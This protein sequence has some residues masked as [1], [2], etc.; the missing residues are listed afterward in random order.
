VAK[1]NWY[2]QEINRDLCKAT[3]L[4]KG[5]RALS[6]QVW[7][8]LIL[9]A[10]FNFL[11]REFFIRHQCEMVNSP[12]QLTLYGVGHLSMEPALEWG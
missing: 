9:S 7:R 1:E 10:S 4:S 8:E 11:S 5:P 12:S 2:S 3:L 6:W